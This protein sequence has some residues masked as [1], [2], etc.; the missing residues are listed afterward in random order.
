M[1]RGGHNLLGG[2]SRVKMPLKTNEWVQAETIAEQM[3]SDS[4]ACHQI[5]STDGRY[6]RYVLT[7]Q[8]A[9]ALGLR[10]NLG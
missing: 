7:V 3:L 8:D 10:A 5:S 1:P 6:A 2:I 4:P 9:A